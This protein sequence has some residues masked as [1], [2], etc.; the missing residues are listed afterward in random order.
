[1]LNVIR[2]RL[3]ASEAT[4]RNYLQNMKKENM[5]FSQNIGVSDVRPIIIWSLNY[6]HPEVI[7]V[8]SG[9]S[10]P[11]PTPDSTGNSP[12]I[13]KSILGNSSESQK[14]TIGN[15]LNTQELIL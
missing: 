4:T 12:G 15:S 6:D 14:E 11:P 2:N 10:L 3:L 9:N 7:K 5:V 13:Q 8:I 1:M